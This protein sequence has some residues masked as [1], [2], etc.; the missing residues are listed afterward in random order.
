MIYIF[1]FSEFKRLNNAASQAGVNSDAPR[2]HPMKNMEEMFSDVVMD[3]ASVSNF[4]T[5][6]IGNSFR[7]KRN[8]KKEPSLKRTR[9]INDSSDDTFILDNDEIETL[10]DVVNDAQSLTPPPS[11][12]K[13]KFQEKHG[14]AGN[15]RK[16]L[17][18]DNDD[19]DSDDPPKITQ[20][21]FSED[22]IREIKERSIE[23]T[24]ALKKNSS[25]SSTTTNTNTGTKYKKIESDAGRCMYAFYNQKNEDR[26]ASFKPVLITV[27]PP[28]LAKNL[29]V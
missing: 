25:G 24:I 29:F 5:P 7:L 12:R 9:E 2:N 21:C 20:D 27:G 23:P 16:R 15:E 19:Q 4:T 13:K 6:A 14:R 10:T 18:H 1:H 28:H 11:P 22:Q 3:P 26:L 17:F 8:S